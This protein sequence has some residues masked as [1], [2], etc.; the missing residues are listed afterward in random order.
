MYCKAG[1]ATEEE[2]YNNGILHFTAI[3]VFKW[4]NLFL[5]LVKYEFSYIYRRIYIYRIFY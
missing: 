5:K 2:M 4:I 1:Q 3:I